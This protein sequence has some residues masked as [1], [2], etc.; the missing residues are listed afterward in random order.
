LC[1]VC[2]AAPTHMNHTDEFV[3]RDVYVTLY[4]FGIFTN[5]HAWIRFFECLLH[6]SYS[7][8][9]KKCQALGEKDQQKLQ[10]KKKISRLL[11]K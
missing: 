10:N 5:I 8:E 11:Q 4:S 1:Y 6:I 3:K 9:I 7:L 2:G